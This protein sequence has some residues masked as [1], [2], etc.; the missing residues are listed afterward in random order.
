[1]QWLKLSYN[2]WSSELLHELNTMRQTDEMCDVRIILQ[3]NVILSAHSNVLAAASPLFKSILTGTVNPEINMQDFPMEI[4]RSVIDFIYTGSTRISRTDLLMLH[5]VSTSLNIP[6]LSDMTQKLLQHSLPQVRSVA[7]EHKSSKIWL[8]PNIEQPSDESDQQ[9]KS[10][11]L[12]LD[13]QD[14]EVNSDSA[15]AEPA[16]GESRAAGQLDGESTEQANIK[17]KV[18]GDTMEE[19]GK[20]SLSTLANQVPIDIRPDGD[21]TYEEQCH[22]V[23]MEEVNKDGDGSWN[24]ENQVEMD[25][26]EDEVG[27]DQE[28]ADETGDDPEH[29]YAAENSQDP[30]NLKVEHRVPVSSESTYSTPVTRGSLKRPMHIKLYS[31]PNKSV[32]SEVPTKTEEP[33]YTFEIFEESADKPLRRSARNKVQKVDDEDEMFDETERDSDDEEFLKS[34]HRRPGSVK[35]KLVKS[36]V[37]G[38]KDKLLASDGYTYVFQR[39]GTFG[40][41]WRCKCHSKKQACAASVKQHDDMF[42]RGPKSHNHGPEP[43]L[44]TIKSENGNMPR[45]DYNATS[46]PTFRPYE[47]GMLVGKTYHIAAKASR[48]GKD[49]LIDSDGYKYAMRR[50]FKHATLWVCSV[51]SKTFSCPASVSQKGRQF[52]PGKHQHNHAPDSNK[53]PGWVPPRKKEK[54]PTEELPPPSIATPAA[55][56][57][58]IYGIVYTPVTDDGKEK[59]VASDGYTYNHRRKGVHAIRWRC[60]C[61]GKGGKPC[62]A[63]VR[64]YDDMFV[65]GWQPHNHEPDR[66][67]IT[68]PHIKR[69]PLTPNDT[70]ESCIEEPASVI[71]SVEESTDSK[72]NKVVT[73]CSSREKSYKIVARATQSGG[74]MLID[75]DGYRYTIKRRVGRKIQWKCAVR[76]RFLTCPAAVSQIGNTYKRGQFEHKH[77]PNCS[78]PLGME[79]YETQRKRKPKIEYKTKHDEDDNFQCNPYEDEYGYKYMI[80]EK[81]SKTKTD[82]LICSDGY[83]Y[84][85]RREGVYGIQWKC[86]MRHPPHKCPGSV[87]QIGEF[88]VRGLKPHTH[89][90]EENLLSGSMPGMVQTTPTMYESN[91]KTYSILHRASKAGKNILEDSD[92][93]RYNFKSSQPNCINWRCSVRNASLQCPATVKQIGNT[94]IPGRLPHRHSPYSKKSIEQEDDST[95]M[96]PLEETSQEVQEQ[97]E[98]QLQ[99]VDNGVVELVLV[100]EDGSTSYELTTVDGQTTFQLPPGMVIQTV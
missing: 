91:G 5:S 1:M 81:A 58:D 3:E 65:V 56:N 31:S 9:G 52:I 62:P 23:K 95:V 97:V 85:A 33:S 25:D 55:P 61:K 26:G 100:A 76:N 4:V 60:T 30:V 34:L 77:K 98:S 8:S 21:A 63:Y 35:Y 78:R 69:Q 11:R 24:E 90:A 7:K 57:Q 74:D 10:A 27:E 80:L 66:N 83:S 86:L 38:S 2:S 19:N 59:L 39:S 20:V 75:S 22:I 54:T 18:T 99:G 48:R 15:M 87:R 14:Q 28:D 71:D 93:Y 29:S 49:L 46:E 17:S 73:K 40:T 51:R 94:F 42:I 6:V 96:M 88:F 67:L 50:K 79:N 53:P 84:T 72:E 89:P 37:K 82:K 13:D 43:N 68:T 64:Q 32:V 92:G 12:S 36:S 44:L 47:S 45:I 70:V 41:Y 16:D